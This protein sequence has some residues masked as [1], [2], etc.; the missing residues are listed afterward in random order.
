M[1]HQHSE[2]PPFPI[3]G[4]GASADG[5]EALQTF[6]EAL[7]AELGAPV[8]VSVRISS[9]HRNE[10]VPILARN[11]K[12]P[13][14]E[15]TGTVPL[16]A[17]RVYIVSPD[18]RLRITDTEVDVLTPDQSRPQRM[19][20]NL[21]L[22]S[23][24]EQYND[25]FAVILSGS[26]ADG[27]SGVKAVKERGGIVLVQ[28]PSEAAFDG[29]SRA[30]IGTFSMAVRCFRPKMSLSRGRIQAL[31]CVSSKRSCSKRRRGCRLHTTR[32]MPLIRKWL[33]PMRNSRASTRN[34]G[35]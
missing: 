17:D 34:T 26:G 19:S 15:V 7:P 23:L 13:V 12:M 20:I 32:P 18:W 28:D 3:V 6:F 22:Q 14:E 1:T 25:V 9:E 31:L 30:A 24:A 11:T 4:I 35:P 29:M 2:S 33:R 27:A 8:V 16:Q 21:F 10:L 5:I